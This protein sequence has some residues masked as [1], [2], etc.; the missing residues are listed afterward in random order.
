MASKRS[1]IDPEANPEITFGAEPVVSLP[2]A[3]F[4]AEPKDE[5]G[6]YVRSRWRRGLDVTVEVWP[7]GWV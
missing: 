6:D 2:G 1:V 7:G 5:S 4:G 3:T